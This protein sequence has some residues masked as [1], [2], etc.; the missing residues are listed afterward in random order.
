M[1]KYQPDYDFTIDDLKALADPQLDVYIDAA[2]WEAVHRND[3][4]EF[5][6]DLTC[7]MGFDL[8][9]GLPGMSQCIFTFHA[10]I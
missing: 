1:D 6:P 4:P 7:G 9:L 10:V 3:L 5:V 2:T 8:D